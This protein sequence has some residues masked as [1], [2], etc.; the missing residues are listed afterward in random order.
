MTTNSAAI[1]IPALNE[2]EALSHLLAELPADLAQWIIVVDNNSTDATAS[3]ARAAGALVVSEPLRG[4]GRACWRGCQAAAEVGAEIVIFMDG[5]GSDDPADLPL[6]RAPVIEGRADLVMGSR[7]SRRSEAGA[8]PMQAR[9]GNYLVSHLLNLM[10]GVDLHDIGSFRVVRRDALEALQMREMTFGWPVE[11]LV[12]AAR[13]RYRIVEVALHYRRR[14]HGRSK[15]AG[16]LVGSV[17]AA[18]CMLTTMM[19]YAGSRRNY[20]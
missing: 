15:V 4:Y 7:V 18:Y 12:K 17:K 8:I 1:V 16:T 5:D 13:A 3:V 2:E 11:M 14:T 10:Y 9:L 6:M 19:R 20:V